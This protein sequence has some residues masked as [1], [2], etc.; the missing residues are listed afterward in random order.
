MA[1]LRKVLIM[2][3][4]TGGHIFPGLAIAKEFQ[5]RGIEVHW[6]GTQE[7]LEAKIVP[8]AHFPLHSI[9]IKGVRGKG[10]RNGMA[11]PWR[12]IK[13]IFQSMKIIHAIQPDVILGLGGFVSGPG[14]IA[15]WLLRRPLVIHEQNAKVGTT[16][17]WL[18]HVATK[19]LEGFPN[20]FKKSKKVITI[21]NPVRPEIIQTGN[22]KQVSSN[23]ASKPKLNLLVLG[24]SLGASAL[25]QIIPQALS[26]LDKLVRPNVIHQS[27]DKHLPET[28]RFYADN[29]VDADIRPF[30]HEMDK[31]Y[32]WADIVLC[33]AGALTVS[34]LCV[35]GLGAILIPFP[36]AIDDHQT[37]NAHY[38]VKNNAA[39]LLQ[40]KELTVDK[41]AN[42]LKEL[43]SNS[44]K[45]VAMAKAAFRLRQPDASKRVLKICEE[46]CA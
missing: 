38:M 28:I 24:G 2:A 10:I 20:T 25:N 8:E 17:K 6:L 3:G 43:C 13:A 44:E 1:K 16:N 39:F 11:A 30:I 22:D 27:G 36:Y 18:S 41:L 7:G 15:S 29:H 9:Q 40:Q 34:E 46:I 12:I 19:T 35:V 23:R 26:Q 42:L 4:G 21:G 32:D 37:T 5:E 31:V 45:C 14:G 33:R